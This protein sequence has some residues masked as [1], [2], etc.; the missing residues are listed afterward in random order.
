MNF[1]KRLLA[2]WRIICK[3]DVQKVPQSKK[4]P[5]KRQLR[6]VEAP[7]ATI[8]DSATF[9]ILSKEEGAVKIGA[10]THVRG[11][12]LTF[13]D[14]GRI[15]IGENCYL[16]DGTRVWSQSSIVIGNDV[17]VSHL[18]D[19]HDT[20]GHPIDP[21]DRVEDSR[22][23]LSGKGYLTPTKT[24]SA[25]VVIEDRVWIG[26]K[27]TIF[28]GVTV[29]EGAIVAACS[30]VTKNVPPM[31]IVAGNPARKVGDVTKEEDKA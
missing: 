28:K 11:E 3:G 12:L 7:D 8:H 4:L 21:D 18:V 19:I 15:T 30:V 22:A 14:G 23:I 27:A 6:F 25:P 24:K 1:S 31:T 13:W 20:D 17:L 2:A 5:R 16:G 26:F 10:G 29:G 9:R